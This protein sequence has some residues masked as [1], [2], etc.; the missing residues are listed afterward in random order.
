MRY[1]YTFHPF[2]LY[3]LMLWPTYS[4]MAVTISPNDVY[5][6]LLQVKADINLL[7]QHFNIQEEI[8]TE[9][10]EVQLLPR[11]TWQKSYE[12][13]FK[14][15]LLRQK[16]NLPVMAVPSWAPTVEVS[17]LHVYE[18]I[19]RIRLELDLL[20]TYLNIPSPSP[21]PP[22]SAPV[23][24]NSAKPDQ[25]ITDN[26]NL[27]NY[28]SYQLDPL[29]GT[30]FNPTTVFGQAMRIF[31]DVNTL[32]TE[33]EIKDDTIPAAQKIDAQPE[34]SFAAALQL[35]RE[36]KRVQNLAHIETVDIY[37]FKLTKT[38]ITPT[39]VF[40]LTGIILAELQTLKAH[41]GLKHSFTPLANFYEDKQPAEIQQML[42]WSVRKLRLINALD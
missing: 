6:Q 18:Q 41:L 34:D 9:N 25:T 11:H 27:L 26:F 15:N 39:E 16:L 12:V 2:L 7:K 3:W 23:M 21:S 35:L 28:L 36:I 10:L 32:I 1:T 33:L 40:A 22:D 42:G 4:A 38:K 24:T 5:L 20:K 13:L 19:C 30:N 8:T 29:N 17:S 37:A 31:A 14:L